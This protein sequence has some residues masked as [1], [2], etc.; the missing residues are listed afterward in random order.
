MQEV[1][2]VSNV[3]ILEKLYTSTFLCFFKIILVLLL[4]KKSE[5]YFMFLVIKTLQTNTSS[6][7]ILSIT[8]VQN[9]D[10]PFEDFTHNLQASAQ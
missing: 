2:A 3:M 10:E 5:L 1:C 8:Q 7:A 9:S 4:T 6:S